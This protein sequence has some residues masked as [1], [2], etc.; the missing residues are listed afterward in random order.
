MSCVSPTLLGK[1]E[2]NKLEMKIAS[3]PIFFVTKVH[4]SNSKDSV[5]HRR[6]EHIDVKYHLFDFSNP[7]VVKWNSKIDCIHYDK[8]IKIS[9][10][11]E[12]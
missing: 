10:V 5:M 9:L 3:V 4:Q 12:I 1:V 7:R 2:I 6:T 8:S 11:C